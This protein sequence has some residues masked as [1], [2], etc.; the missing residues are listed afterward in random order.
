MVVTIPFPRTI[1]LFLIV[2][3]IGLSGSSE[4][5]FFQLVG[6]DNH[7]DE[8]VDGFKEVGIRITRGQKSVDPK[9]GKKMNKIQATGIM[10]LGPV[11]KHLLIEGD[12]ILLHMHGLG[13]IQPQWRIVANKCVHVQIY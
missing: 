7:K 2:F 12:V 4:P 6:A 11:L 5:L 9:R 10:A 3:S 1:S 13:E 8:T